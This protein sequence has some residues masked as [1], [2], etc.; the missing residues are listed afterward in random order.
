MVGKEKKGNNEDEREKKEKKTG[1]QKR[2]GNLTLKYWQ[3]MIGRIT[4][5]Q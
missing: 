1:S 3:L 2:K 4:C 5:F